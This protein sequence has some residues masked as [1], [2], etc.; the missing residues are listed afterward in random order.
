MLSWPA[1]TGDRIGVHVS[2]VREGV[3][4]VVREVIRE[5]IREG[6]R[7]ALAPLFRAGNRLQLN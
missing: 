7:M 3:R 1:A 6:A 5:V 4:E 2:G